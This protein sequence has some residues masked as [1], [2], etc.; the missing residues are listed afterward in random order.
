MTKDSISQDR[1]VGIVSEAALALGRNAE[2]FADVCR[3]MT[4]VST[5]FL[6]A[7][8]MVASVART[9]NDSHK[10][11]FKGQHESASKITLN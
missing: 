11:P 4:V 7:N 1:H 3:T 6:R 5:F 2:G 8:F 9:I 10:G